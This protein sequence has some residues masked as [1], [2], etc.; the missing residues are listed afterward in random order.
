MFLI[1]D[2]AGHRSQLVSALVF[3]LPAIRTSAYKIPVRLQG[4]PDAKKTMEMNS[5]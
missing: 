4:F 3:E 2:L 1:L 5:A